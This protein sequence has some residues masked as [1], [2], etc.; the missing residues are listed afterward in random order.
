MMFDGSPVQTA[1]RRLLCQGSFSRPTR[2]VSI[3][4]TAMVGYGDMSPSDHRSDRLANLLTARHGAALELA[5]S[6]LMLADPCS[7]MSNSPFWAMDQTAEHSVASCFKHSCALM[8]YA[9]VSWDALASSREVSKQTLHRKYAHDAD[10]VFESAQRYADVNVADLRRE[11]TILKALAEHVVDELETELAEAEAIW[12][13]RRSQPGWW[14][15]GNQ[16]TT[17]SAGGAGVQIS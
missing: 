7:E 15:E 14:R 6:A 9:G 11:L 10:S 5:N 3:L 17:G 13:K 12:E 4:L 1:G 2:S 16:Q 8:L